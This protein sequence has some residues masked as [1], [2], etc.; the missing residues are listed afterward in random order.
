MYKQ[1]EREA[2]KWRWW[3]VVF[4]AAVA[5]AA[6][7]YESFITL[8][9]LNNKRQN[10]IYSHFHFPWNEEEREKKGKEK[11]KWIFYIHRIISKKEE[12]KKGKT[13]LRKIIDTQN[14]VVGNFFFPHLLDEGN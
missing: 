14:A 8:F 2:S 10:T 7:Y 4:V 9:R 3:E 1:N 12:E 6:S 13:I 5:A 11:L